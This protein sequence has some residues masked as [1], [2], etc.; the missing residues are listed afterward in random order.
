MLV[1]GGLQ[2]DTG[3]VGVLGWRGW[4]HSQSHRQPLGD[5]TEPQREPLRGLGPTWP[6]LCPAVQCE[7]DLAQNTLA[8]PK[9][10]RIKPESGPSL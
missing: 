4:G 2:G 7:S 5:S 9:A 3:G 10:L 8:V 1:G 6:L